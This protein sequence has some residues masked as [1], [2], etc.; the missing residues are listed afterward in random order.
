M[1]AGPPIT[2]PSGA[3]SAS[4]ANRSAC[5]FRSRGTHVNRVPKGARLLASMASG[6]MSGCLIFQLPDICSTTSLESSRTSRSAP[7]AYSR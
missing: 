3:S 1:G 5:L 4:L 2:V 7:S 6:F